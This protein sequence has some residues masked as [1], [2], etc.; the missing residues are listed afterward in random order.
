[1]RTVQGSG[2]FLLRQKVKK[3]QKVWYIK[4][5]SLWENGTL[6]LKVVRYILWRNSSEL[7]RGLS[8]VKCHRFLLISTRW[9][10]PPSL[11]FAKEN[12]SWKR[13]GG[14]VQLCSGA[15]FDAEGGGWSRRRESF[16]KISPND[17]SFIQCCEKGGRRR[18]E[19]PSANDS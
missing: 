15:C 16:P 4:P 9:D 13:G 17:A 5:F 3:I 10:N 19:D 18:E 14:G 2:I 8:F 11:I 1:M 12:F 6:S 7:R